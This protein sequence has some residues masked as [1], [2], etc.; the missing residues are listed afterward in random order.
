MQVSLRNVPSSLLVHQPPLRYAGFR[1]WVSSLDKAYQ[2]LELRT[3][4]D[5]DPPRRV[6]PHDLRIIALAIEQHH[7]H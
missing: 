3:S 6:R 7:R 1:L 5:P 2:R 4:I